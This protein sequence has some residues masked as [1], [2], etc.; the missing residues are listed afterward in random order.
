MNILYLVTKI[1]IGG[2]EAVVRDLAV[3]ANKNGHNVTILTF[4]S[5]SN[6]ITET[7]I[8]NYIRII[9][10]PSRN[11]FSL[12][13]LIFFI[14]IIKAKNIRLSMRIQKKRIFIYHLLNLSLIYLLLLL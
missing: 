5:R 2:T 6:H 12:K 8:K 9:N 3:L 13:N 7:I 1:S 4:L 11:L 10:F 14:K